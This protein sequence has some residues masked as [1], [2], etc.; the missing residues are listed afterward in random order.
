MGSR[1]RFII[2]E[3]LI[4]TWNSYFIPWGSGGL[5]SHRVHTINE[6]VS[7]YLEWCT[8]SHNL[9]ILS[10]IF[11]VIS[12][13]LCRYKQTHHSVNEDNL[14]SLICSDIQSWAGRE[15]PPSTATFHLWIQVG[16]FICCHFQIEKREKEKVKAVPGSWDVITSGSILLAV[17]YS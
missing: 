3:Q 2:T 4:L 15:A 12:Y 11:I 9:V 13:S 5:I 1:S 8:Q 10:H 14:F 17:I 16:V 6:A 7:W